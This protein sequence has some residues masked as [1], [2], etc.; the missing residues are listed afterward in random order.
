ME[1]EEGALSSD[2]RPGVQCPG[3]FS[4]LLTTLAHFKHIQTGWLCSPAATQRLRFLRMHER[5]Q[6]HA[7]DPLGLRAR[8]G[9]RC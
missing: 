3:V 9:R 1:V 4:F 6:L 2:Q 7:G 5:A 8:R